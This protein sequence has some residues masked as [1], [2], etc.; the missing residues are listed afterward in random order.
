MIYINYNEPASSMLHTKFCGKRPTGSG[1][2]DFLKVC[3]IYSHGSHLGHVTCIIYITFSSPFLAAPVAE[4]LRSL[5][6][7]LLIIRSSHRCGFAPRTGHEFICETSHV[8]LAGVS[9]GFSP[10]T[11]VFAPPT[12]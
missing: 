12:D 1:E 3:A 10:G 2:E 7:V 5:T 11:P 4:W 6:S 8:L 9:G